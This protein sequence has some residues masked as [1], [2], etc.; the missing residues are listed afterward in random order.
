MPGPIRLTDAQLTAVYR[1]A[2]PIDP[3]RR[4]AFL[5]RVAD[6]LAGC[7]SPGDGDVFRAV[8]DAQAATLSPP[9]QD[10]RRGPR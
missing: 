2:A 6:S 10:G 5:Q 4:D 8:R 7:R 3:A 1:A 9:R